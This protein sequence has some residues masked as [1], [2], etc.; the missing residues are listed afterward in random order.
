MVD[1]L[2]LCYALSVVCATGVFIFAMSVG[3]YKRKQILNT[4]SF[5]TARRQVRRAKNTFEKADIL[6]H[7]HTLLYI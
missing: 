3:Y 6:K 4:E 5:I 7:T 2:A 1:Y